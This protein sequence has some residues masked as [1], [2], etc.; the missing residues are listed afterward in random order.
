LAL[1]F[2]LITKTNCT[3]L[4]RLEKQTGQGFPG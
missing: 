3:L 1:L 2:D 4:G